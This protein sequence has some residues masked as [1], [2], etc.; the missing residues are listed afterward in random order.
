MRVW[1]YFFWYPLV[2]SYTVNC[3]VIARLSLVIDVF[4]VLFPKFQHLML[5]MDNLNFVWFKESAGNHI[6]KL[7]VKKRNIVKGSAVR[8]YIAHG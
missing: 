2:K 1:L 5:G 6:R 8:G 4:G 3:L 7:L